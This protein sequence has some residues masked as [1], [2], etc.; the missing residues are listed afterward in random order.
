MKKKFVV[1]G[2]GM[3][4][5]WMFEVLFEV[6]FDVYD[7]MLFNVELCGN[8]NCLMLL[9][10][11]LGE[12]IYVQIVMY[13]VDWYV[14]YGV[15]CCFGEFVVCIDCDVCWVQF[16]QF[17]VE[18]DVLVIVIGLVLFIILVFGKDLFG[19][20]VYCDLE[21]M[22]VMMV[23]VGKDVVV[24]GG[25]LLGLEVVVGMVVCGVCVMVI[26]LMG[27]LMECQLDFVVGYLL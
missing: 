13:D 7:V 9:L 27:Y 1:I 3:V 18:Y 2:V 21:D 16:N 23:I 4:L 12:K 20:V 8:Y 25:G 5:G 14:C 17:S 6:V 22:Q 10:V 11:L 26:Y 24:I 15:D 19:V